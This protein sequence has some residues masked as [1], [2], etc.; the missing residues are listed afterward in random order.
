[1]ETYLLRLLG[2]IV[3]V[4]EEY[5]EDWE[6]DSEGRVVLDEALTVLGRPKSVPS[7]YFG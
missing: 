7:E 3:D 6:P 4:F 5:A 2:D 1:M